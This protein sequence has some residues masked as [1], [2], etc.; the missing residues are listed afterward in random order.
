MLLVKSP[1]KSEL[2]QLLQ[3]LLS[4]GYSREEVV[5]WWRAIEQTVHR[6]SEQRSLAV[7]DGFWYFQSLS[8]LDV[9]INLGDGERYFIRDTD[10][11]EYLLDL[12]QIDA[13]P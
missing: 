11:E 6:P 7:E 9:P 4:G 3:G 1:D 5:S 12:Q 13:T 8:I 2:I 10:I